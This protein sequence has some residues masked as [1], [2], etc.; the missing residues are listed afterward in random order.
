VDLLYEVEDQLAE[1]KLGGYRGLEMFIISFVSAVL[2]F[3]SKAI[4]VSSLGKRI[5]R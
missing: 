5:Y 2:F 4:S 3:F 1:S